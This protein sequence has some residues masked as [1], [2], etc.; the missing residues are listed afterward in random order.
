MPRT[1]SNNNKH[2]RKEQLPG[3]RAEQVCLHAVTNF[4][5][6]RAHQTKPGVVSRLGTIGAIRQYQFPECTDLRNRVKRWFCRALSQFE[7]GDV[8]A[9]QK[10]P[11][12]VSNATS[13]GFRQALEY[14][15]AMARPACAAMS[16]PRYYGDHQRIDP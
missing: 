8:I 2:Q 6:R 1:T 13:A 9:F 11:R 14:L 3:S 10:L 16:A 12:Q 5:S 15:S 4:E 7:W